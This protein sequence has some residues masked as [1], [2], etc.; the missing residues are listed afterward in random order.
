MPIVFH[1]QGNSTVIAVEGR[2]DIA[3]SAAFEAEV[4]ALLGNGSTAFLFDCTKLNYVSSA[5]L[6]AF[7]VLNKRVV[8]AGHRLCLCALQPSVL[9]VFDMSGFS[10][11]FPLRATVAEALA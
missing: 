8:A 7:L 11:I 5:G 6:R 10:D 1:Q 9:Q 4:A 2:L 3:S